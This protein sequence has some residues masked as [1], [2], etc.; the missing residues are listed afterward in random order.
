MKYCKIIDP[1]N[2]QVSFINLL[3]F[4]PRENKW[5]IKNHKLPLRLEGNK[6]LSN[7]QAMRTASFR[8]T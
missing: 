6:I 3:C 2:V 7:A 5:K 8:M 4:V 1:R